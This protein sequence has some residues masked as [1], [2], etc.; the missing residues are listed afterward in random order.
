MDTAL[1]Q[2]RCGTCGLANS[3]SNTE[4]S[5]GG[6]RPDRSH[7]SQDNGRLL[8]ALSNTG[9]E[10][11]QNN[12]NNVAVHGDVSIGNYFTQS[13]EEDEAEERETRKASPGRSFLSSFIMTVS[14]IAISVATLC[15]G[16]VLLFFVFVFVKAY[17]K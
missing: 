14:A 5:C 6:Q 10:N 11:V 2:W 16:S 8:S 1:V 7:R 15:M 4:C 13:I 3:V 12:V 9:N 17:V